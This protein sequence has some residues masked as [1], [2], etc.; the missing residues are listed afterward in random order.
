[1]DSKE[2]LSVDQLAFM[3]SFNPLKPSCMHFTDGEVE[4]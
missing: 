3:P 4:A 1:M 2:A